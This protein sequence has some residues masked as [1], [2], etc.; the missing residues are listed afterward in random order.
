MTEINTLLVNPI[1]ADQKI[2]KLTKRNVTFF[3][4]QCS[5]I[6]PLSNSDRS[7]MIECDLLVQLEYAY[8]FCSSV[9]L[10]AISLIAPRILPAEYSD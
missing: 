9:S 6:M 4:K 7:S 3:V 1:T 8:I 10:F 5:V 2:G